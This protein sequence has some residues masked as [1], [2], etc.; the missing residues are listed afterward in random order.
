M[1][2]SAR[3][4][5]QFRRG[6]VLGL[7]MAE[8]LLLLI[9]LLMLILGVRLKTQATHIAALEKERDEAQ[10]TL[11][12]MQPFMD[13]LSKSQKFDINQDYV[14]VQQQLAD[15]NAR[16]KDAA[17]SVDLVRQAASLAPPDATPE[18][19]TRA[20]LNEAAIGRQ[21]LD[22]ARRFAPDLPAEQAVAALINAAT[23]EQSLKRGGTPDELLAAAGACKAD[24]QSC[25]NQ[26]TF[27]NA[28]LNAKTGGFD[29]PP[30]WVDA[31]GKIQYIFDAS[32]SDAG[33]YVEDKSVTGRESDQ[34]KLPL[35][36][37]RYGEPLGRGEFSTAFAPL[38]KWSNEH[39]CRFYVRLYDDMREGDRAAYKELRGTVEGYFRILLSY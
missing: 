34:E 10:S 31:K 5:K 38:L 2:G 26:T 25:K 19:A 32:L 17:L 20:L 28:R 15:A 35:S 12:A 24:L 7:T 18:E 8:A 23:I 9:F 16:L 11:V 13:K 37:A 14:R 30:C 22:A 27:L 39:G 36:R 6:V 33:I 29:L 3:D 1:I 4:D 21:A